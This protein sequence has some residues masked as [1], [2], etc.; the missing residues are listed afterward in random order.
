MP[1]LS[2]LDFLYSLHSHM[3]VFQIY[4]C[5]NT[6]P[7][8]IAA[9]NHKNESQQ[10]PKTQRYINIP[11]ALPTLSPGRC[12][13]TERLEE[14]PSTQSTHTRKSK[15]CILFI[16]CIIACNNFRQN[17]SFKKEIVHAL[18]KEQLVK[19]SDNHHIRFYC[20]LWKKMEI[21]IFVHFWL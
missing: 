17:G 18:L 14:W 12:L 6:F 10:V 19:C 9:T 15:H 7:Q 2:S 16:Y 4:G 21:P 8:N 11:L 3:K 20:C 5:S 1:V 13:T